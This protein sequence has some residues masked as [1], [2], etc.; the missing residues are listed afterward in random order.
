MNAS[1]D[2]LELDEAT[3]L[4]VDDQPENIDVI[5]A[6]LDD[7]FSVRVA[8]RGEVA[9][10]I[11]A[12]GGIDL[13]LLDVMMPGLDG[14]ETCR[15]LKS[16]VNTRNIPVVFL[17]SKDTLEDE[18]LGLKLGAVDFIRKPSHPMVVLTRCMNTLALFEA[19]RR[20]KVQNRQLQ[21][22]NAKLENLSIIDGLTGVPNRRRFDDFLKTEWNRALRERTPLSVII[23]DIDYFKLFNDGYG[24]IEGDRCL[25]KVAKSL[26]ESLPRSVDMLA[27]YGGEEFGCILPDTDLDGMIKLGEHLRAKV[28]SLAIPHEFSKVVPNVTISLGGATM[29]P[30]HGQEPY[31]LIGIAD[32]RLYQAKKRGR[33]FLVYSDA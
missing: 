3:I 1:E 28:L 27:R 7:H 32:R 4:L 26:M 13:I 14:F 31:Y 8:T 18:V 25:I 22:L 20:F 19:R 2:N 33:N 24:H 9:L 6:A 12:R 17:T 23:I 11:A 16:A 29:T 21:E 30:S 10:R 15:R 5:K